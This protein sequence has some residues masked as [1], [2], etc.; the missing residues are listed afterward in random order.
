[1]VSFEEK[2]KKKYTKIF[3]VARMY[4]Q[5]MYALCISGLFCKRDQKMNKTENMK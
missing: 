1:L 3:A 4:I 5:G 2:S